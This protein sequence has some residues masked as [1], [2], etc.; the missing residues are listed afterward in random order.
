MGWT[1]DIS[2]MGRLADRV[3]DLAKVPSRAAAPVAKAIKGLIAEEFEAQAD[4][5]GNAWQP[6][7][8][9]TVERWGEHPILDLTGNMRGGIDV[10]PMRP[11]G[12]AVTI[13]H[14]GAPHQTGWSGPQGSGPAR[15]ILPGGTMPARW[16]EAI[17]AEVSEAFHATAKGAA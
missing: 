13:P 6:H 7:A 4:P 1:G 15:P 11:A 9:A 2:R 8:D 17:R 12:V 16:R 14:P 3:R 10:S 5:Y